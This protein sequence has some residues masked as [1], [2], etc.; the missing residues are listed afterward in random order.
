MHLYHTNF[1]T[2]QIHLNPRVLE[3][4]R[5]DPLFVLVSLVADATRKISGFFLFKKK[6]DSCVVTDGYGWLSSEV[7]R[8]GDY[9]VNK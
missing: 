5:F 9:A 2:I 3:P 8:I 4:E 1:F 6:Q 7:I